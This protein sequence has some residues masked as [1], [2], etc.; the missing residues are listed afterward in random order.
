MSTQD[1]AVAGDSINIPSL[2]AVIVVG[3]IVIR[4]FLGPSSN[5]DAS[6]GAGG[7]AGRRVDPRA[8]EQI[9]SMFPQASRRDVEWDLRRNGGSV[10]TTTERILG[11]RG[12][13]IPPPSFQPQTVPPNHPESQPKPTIP[14]H[15]DL[16][17]RYNL[18]SRIAESSPNDEVSASG[19]DARSQ[20]AWSQDKGE[21]HRMMQ[22]RRDDMILAARRKLLE[23]DRKKAEEAGK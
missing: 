21:R 23:E 8:V 15:P 7:R 17:T 20:N 12:L 16:I 13:D 19:A 22:Q 10:A 3:F 6:S 11:G 5:G 1:P 14:S 18:Q 9:I 2:I 4:W